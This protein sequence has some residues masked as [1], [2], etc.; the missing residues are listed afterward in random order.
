MACDRFLSTDELLKLILATHF[1]SI[2]HH[3]KS[4]SLLLS[5]VLTAIPPDKHAEVQSALVALL[6]HPLI[7]PQ[8]SKAQEA[9]PSVSF[10]HFLNFV[11]KYYV[12]PPS[13][14]IE[15]VSRLGCISSLCSVSIIAPLR[16]I[17]SI[18]VF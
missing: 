11:R 7:E 12:R 6:N 16:T 9:P 15:V 4:E 5:L 1:E 17:G 18:F 14:I 2:G 10:L 8:E 13:L 3:H